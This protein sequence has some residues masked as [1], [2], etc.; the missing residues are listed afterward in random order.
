MANPTSM[1]PESLHKGNSSPQVNCVL[2]EDSAE[3]AAGSLPF[4]SLLLFCVVFF[5]PLLIPLIQYRRVF[6]E[7]WRLTLGQ[8]M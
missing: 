6:S 8:R 3:G 7:A 5:F 2:Q 4:V 1:F